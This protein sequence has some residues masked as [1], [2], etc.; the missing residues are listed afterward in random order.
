MKSRLDP[1]LWSTD[2]VLKTTT[3]TTTN[4]T[5]PKNIHAPP[6][7]PPS[8]MWRRWKQVN[9]QQVDLTSFLASGASFLGREAAERATKLREVA[10]VN[11]TKD[12]FESLRGNEWTL[13]PGLRT[14]F[15][16]IRTNKQIPTT[17]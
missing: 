13:V 14:I 1:G 9:L 5:K 4:K 2:N 3:T 11:R 12:F 16:K 17:L 10:F 6:L 8:C 15:K 7:P